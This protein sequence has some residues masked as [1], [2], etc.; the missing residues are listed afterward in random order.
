MAW[1]CETFDYHLVGRRLQI[2]SD[3]KPLVAILGEKD[4]SC[5]PVRVQKFKL[6]LMRYD[7]DIFHTLGKDMYIADALSR[8]NTVSFNEIDSG[9]CDDVEIY[10]QSIVFTS[11]DCDLKEQEVRDKSSIHCQVICMLGGQTP[12]TLCTVIGLV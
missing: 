3:H 10:V 12:L 8:P 6:R 1:A 2:E 9:Y 7:Y 4:L 5:L 11:A